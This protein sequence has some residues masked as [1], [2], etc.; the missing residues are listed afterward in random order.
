TGNWIKV[1]Q[2]LPVRIQLDKKELAKHPL[3]I[4]LSMIVDVHTDNQK[5][6]LLSKR[7]SDDARFE[8]N[9]YRQS[10]AGVNH[11]INTIIEDNDAG[12]QHYLAKE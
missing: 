12:A 6:P 7:H 1:V 3:R 10:L 8:T 9:V 5:G 11:M 4:G 2:R